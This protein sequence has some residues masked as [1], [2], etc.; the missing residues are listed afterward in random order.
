MLC[1]FNQ[2]I[3]A[4]FLALFSRTLPPTSRRSHRTQALGQ[5][6][7]KDLGALRPPMDRSFIHR[8][9]CHQRRSWFP[10]PE[11]PNDEVPDRLHRS[12]SCL[13]FALVRRFTLRLLQCSQDGRVRSAWREIEPCA[14]F[15]CTFSY[16]I[17]EPVAFSH[18]QQCFPHQQT[19]WSGI[20]ILPFGLARIVHIFFIDFWIGCFDHQ[21]YALHDVK[22]T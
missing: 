13:L 10:D 20:L 6:S 2:N 18:G 19:C 3:I 1:N 22:V 16:G 4:N 9:R 21:K 17:N 12:R 5:V 7:A 11:I 8:S 14:I 15:R